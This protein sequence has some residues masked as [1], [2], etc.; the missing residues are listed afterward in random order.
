VSG[1]Q[2]RVFVGP[3]SNPK[4]EN[5]LCE[6]GQNRLF[7]INCCCTAMMWSIPSVLKG[8]VERGPFLL[9]IMSSAFSF[10]LV[11]MGLCGIVR[12]RWFGLGRLA[13]WLARLVY[14]KIKLEGPIYPCGD[15]SEQSHVKPGLS[16]ILARTHVDSLFLN[17]FHRLGGG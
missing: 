13:Q 8:F 4:P 9:L 1:A 7:I 10:A 11:A 12:F 14:T 15:R 6:G 16:C 17:F 2:G 3:E 5:Y